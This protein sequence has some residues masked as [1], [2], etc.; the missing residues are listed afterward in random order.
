MVLKYLIEKEFKQFRRNTF[1]PRLAVMFPLVIILV[2]PWVATFEIQNIS[3]TV[4]DN[5]ATATSQ[6]LIT[7]INGSNY[8]IMKD[9]VRNYDAALIDIEKSKSDIILA[10]PKDFEKNILTK[11]GADVQ[12]S[13]N[14]V[15]GI[16]GGIGSGYMNSIVA[17]F[18]VEIFNDR[19]I[20]ITPPINISVQNK[21][22]PTL[23]YKFFMI[24]ALMTMVLIMLCGF[25]PALNIVSEKEI[26]T[27]EQ[28][29]VTPVSK[30]SFILAKLIP[31]WLMGFVVLTICF[32]LSWIVYGYT[33]KG[34]FLSIYLAA[35]LFVL[36]ISGIGLIISNYSA[37]MQQAMFV[38]FFFVMIFMLMSGLFTPV[39]SMP[40]WAQNI[41]TFIP[42]RYFID[43]M[44]STFLKGSTITDN[45][46][47]YIALSIFAILINAWAVISYRKQS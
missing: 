11:K 37:T 22:N 23:D 7:K 9:M 46:I 47:N 36:V 20:N 8:F 17:E 38:M 12:I 2:F 41:A 39:K 5:D 43:I 16:K 42:P 32:A 24:P 30:A 40:Y 44:R 35:M 6:R 14:S 18:I 33:P 19:G 13:A 1:M 45:A 25:L 21:Y 15:N 31:Y 3:V 34:N 4:I 27:I 28:I 29:N 10:I 26:G